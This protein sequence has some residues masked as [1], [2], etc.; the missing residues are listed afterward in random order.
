MVVTLADGQE[1]VYEGPLTVR[2]FL[3]GLR[4]EEGL[5]DL[6]GLLEV[7]FGGQDPWSEYQTPVR[8]TVQRRGPT[9]VTIDGRIAD[10]PE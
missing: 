1:W 6:E 5:S 3:R 4:L 7:A 8:I 9:R 10:S 2:Q